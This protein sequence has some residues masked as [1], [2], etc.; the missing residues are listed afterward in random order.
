MPPHT[1]V[2][3]VIPAYR[4]D[5]TLA[6]C[7][8]A[9]LG[10]EFDGSYEV[11]LVVSADDARGLPTIAHHPRLRA[12]TRVPR[13]HAREARH[14]AIDASNSAMLAFTDADAVPSRRWLQE[15]VDASRG[16]TCMVAGAITNGT[17]RSWSGTAEYIVEFSDLCPQ[18]PPAGAWHGALCNL[19]VPRPLWERFGPFADLVGGHDTDLTTRARAEGCFVFAPRAEV[20]HLNRTGLGPVLDH[21]HALGRYAA[22]VARSDLPYRG[23]M[24]V[25]HTPLA[26]VAAT[27]RFLSAELRVVRWLRGQRIRG[28]L[29]TPMLALMHAWWGAGLVAEGVRIDLRRR[30]RRRP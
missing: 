25:R 2:S 24:L 6:A 5:A 13:L 28:L 16:G 11:V 23:R 4:A 26:P 18:R 20:R 29:L 3:V 30:R 7:L 1:D 17:P 15:L 22:H 12:R 27:A 19:L 10:Q 14:E 21:Q 8:D 9:V